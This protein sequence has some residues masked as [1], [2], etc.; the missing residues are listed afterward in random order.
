MRLGEAG[1]TGSP[2]LQ[3]RDFPRDFRLTE[4]SF[5]IVPLPRHVQPELY[6]VPET[7]GEGTGLPVFP[8]LVF[9]FVSVDRIGGRNSI[10][11]QVIRR[12]RA[13]RNARNFQ[14]DLFVGF[15]RDFRGG[16]KSAGVR[17]FRRTVQHRIR[18]G[19][20]D[21]ASGAFTG[22]FVVL[23]HGHLLL[24]HALTVGGCLAYACARLREHVSA[25]LRVGTAEGGRR[26]LRRPPSRVR[27]LLGVLGVDSVQ[28]VGQSPQCL[29]IT[30]PERFLS[31]RLQQHQQIVESAEVFAV[32]SDEPVSLAYQVLVRAMGLD[33]G[34]E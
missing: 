33:L 2:R 28:V 22:A 29:H 4:C 20:V 23:R 7:I 26:G 32:N 10:R 9:L 17:E 14:R 27:L 8:F 34:P 31:D 12:I 5:A 16:E 6:P 3:E 21:Q 19:E 30:A 15:R 11:T 13:S 18:G 25:R 24:D 1:F